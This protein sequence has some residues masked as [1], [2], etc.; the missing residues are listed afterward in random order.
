MAIGRN[1]LSPCA[2]GVSRG[3]RTSGDKREQSE[4][5]ITVELT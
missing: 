1:L 4:D 5:Q 3:R 2:D